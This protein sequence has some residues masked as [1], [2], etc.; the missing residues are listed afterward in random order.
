MLGAIT[1][2]LLSLH[3]G[4][5]GASGTLLEVTGGGYARV[6]C[7]FSAASSG[8]RALAAAVDFVGPASGGAAWI[9]VWNSTG[10]TFLA[11][12]QITAGDVTF[13]ASGEF[14]VT[15]ATQLTLTDPV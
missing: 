8:A 9:G 3:T 12:I 2:N 5:P 4:D 7:S 11:R 14:R 15:T 13:N 6:A 10:P 1:P